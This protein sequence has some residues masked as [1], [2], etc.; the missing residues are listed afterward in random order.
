MITLD[1]KN[2]IK[3][4]SKA[5]LACAVSGFGVVMIIQY[6]HGV[7]P[8]SLF[9][10]GLS[11]HTGLSVGTIALIYNIILLLLS[12]I[13]NKK[14]L[15]IGTLVYT[16]TLG[17]FMDTSISIL[18]EL[19]G[20]ATLIGFFIGH[21]ILCIGNASLLYLDFGLSSL[22]AIIQW[23]VQKFH[24]RYGFIKVSTDIFFA[25]AGI[26]LGSIIQWGS[27]YI[28]L[29]TGFIVDFLVERYR[30]ICVKRKATAKTY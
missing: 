10:L 19:S 26:L 22:D 23:V 8:L 2:M 11:T 20:T 29:T 16:I 14:K 24:I 1:F 28:M 17:Y 13:V 15:G 18:P 9:Q 6:S 7:D 30:S 12:F 5:V 3:D 25:C 27:L 4:T 21:F